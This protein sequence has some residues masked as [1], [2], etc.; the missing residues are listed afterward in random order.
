M[1]NILSISI[2]VEQL[3]EQTAH[4]GQM[5][6]FASFAGLFIDVIPIAINAH[7][8]VVSWVL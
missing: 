3:K 1:E 5:R 7:T 2:F 8:F 6:R 4:H